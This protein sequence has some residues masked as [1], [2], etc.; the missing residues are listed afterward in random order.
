MCV[1]NFVKHLNRDAQ[2]MPANPF[3]EKDQKLFSIF[4]NLSNISKILK[5]SSMTILTTDIGFR[6]HVFGTSFQFL[7]QRLR[8]DVLDG[9]LGFI[10]IIIK[11]VT[12]STS[13]NFMEGFISKTL[14]SKWKFLQ[15]FFYFLSLAIYRLF[16]DVSQINIF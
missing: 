1:S 8:Y 6:Y 14:L 13:N 2:V 4:Y 15:V 10:K 16:S 12:F 11:R 9:S 7:P 3:L 5:L